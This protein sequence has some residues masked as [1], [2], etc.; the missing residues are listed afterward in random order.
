MTKNK[1]TKKKQI[2]LQIKIHNEHL[3]NHSQI[4]K[5]NKLDN[6]F[7]TEHKTEQN[8]QYKDKDNIINDQNQLNDNKLNIGQLSSSV[9]DLMKVFYNTISDNK[10]VKHNTHTLKI[11]KSISS[12]INTIKQS[13]K[14]K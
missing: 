6:T 1:R 13:T 9:L 14:H 12:K 11:T 3:K 5:H 8:K 10:I 4:D 7:T 2:P